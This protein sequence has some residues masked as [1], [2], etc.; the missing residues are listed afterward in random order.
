MQCVSA[1]SQY[2][3]ILNIPKYDK[4]AFAKFG[5]FS[6]FSALTLQKFCQVLHGI[7]LVH[8]SLGQHLSYH[9]SELAC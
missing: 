2:R 1:T 3:H 4:M 5:F 8:R 6:I 7:F 9:R